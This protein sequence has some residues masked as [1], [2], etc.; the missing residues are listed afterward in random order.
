MML[1]VSALL[2]AC[3]AGATLRAVTPVATVTCNS[4]III[5]PPVL[6]GPGDRVIFDRLFV[7]GRDRVPGPNPQPSGTKPFLFYAKTGVSIRRGS[8][9]LVEVPMSWRARVAIEWGDSGT[10]SRVRFLPCRTGPKWITYAGGFHFRDKGGGCVPLRVTVLSR[11][12]TI[13]FG[14][15]RRC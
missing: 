2:A 3:S 1:G 6:P 10:T 5:N 9:A 8:G 7:V 12:R 14:A 4:S 13:L 15:G 11:T